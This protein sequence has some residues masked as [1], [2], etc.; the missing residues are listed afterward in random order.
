MRR[1]CTIA[2]AFLVLPLAACAGDDDGQ[3]LTV[4]AASSLT[5]SFEDLAEQF[6]A[7]HEGVEVRFSF[8]S[9]TTLAEQAADG[10]PGD[11][12]ATADE[13]S[14][15]I[16][17]DAGALAADPTAFAVNHLVLAVPEGNPAGVQSLADL[18]EVDWVRCSDDVPCG[19]V[20]IDLLGAGP[21]AGPPASLEVDG[22]AVLAKVA[23][24][25]ADAGLV[26]A[27]DALAASDEV[28]SVDIPRAADFPTTYYLAPLAQAA[29][30][31]L[32][33]DWVGLVRSAAGQ[34]V[35]VDAG[36]GIP[37]TR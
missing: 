30:D 34:A 27:T 11:V 14:V 33:D 16:A 8:G 31:G 7:D 29:D 13:T 1:A 32:A 25:E 37:D 12:L 22:K 35:L 23:A 24:G 36:F 2:Q 21:D 5:E 28:D 26:Y 17:D 10:A 6:E 4:L 19:R 15:A 20:A 9:S 18:G 3:V